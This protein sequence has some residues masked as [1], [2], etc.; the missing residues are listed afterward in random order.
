V[1]D[2]KGLTIVKAPRSAPTPRIS[3]TERRRER[4]R[5]NGQF[6]QAAPLHGIAGLLDLRSAGGHAQM[7]RFAE[8]VC[9]VEPL[10]NPPISRADPLG[11]QPQ[12]ATDDR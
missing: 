1:T 4:R 5:R 6:L 10:A 9:L 3:K 11:H 8:T 7:G 2:E 12:E